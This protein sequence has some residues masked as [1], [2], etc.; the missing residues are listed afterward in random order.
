MYH[1]CNILKETDHEKYLLKVKRPVF[2]YKGIY[3]RVTL[4]QL[5]SKIHHE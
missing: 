1:R 3:T 4:S 2:E 5:I